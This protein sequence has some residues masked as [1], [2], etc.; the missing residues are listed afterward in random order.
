[1]PYPA[2]YGGVID[3]YYKIIA[4]HNL[5]IRIHLHCFTNN[6]PAQK[7]LLQYCQTVTYYKRK[8]ISGYRT[9]LP[10][11]VSSR[12]N[13]KL[14]TNLQKDTHPILFEGIHC[15]YLL[16]TNV[17]GSRKMCIRL[18][19]VEHLYYKKLAALEKNFFLKLHYLLEA[20]QLYKY[21]KKIAKSVQIFAPSTKD[22][23]DYEALFDADNISFL[24]VFLPYQQVISNMGIGKYC[25]YH[26]N[27][28]IN[29][30]ETAALWLIEKVFTQLKIPLV[31]AGNKPT[32]K[33]INTIKKYPNVSLVTSPIDSTMQLLIAN[34]HVNVLPSFNETGVK[35]KLLNALYNGRYCLVNN[36]GVAGSQLNKLCVLAES[37]QEYRAAITAIMEQP[38]TIQQIQ[39]R[40][41]ELKKI[42]NNKQS[43]L[44]IQTALL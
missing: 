32:I 15:T 19:N 1:M 38:F 8:T 13:N 22:C 10:F 42:Y 23:A 37:E 18:F 30:N 17:L 9:N 35:L 24:P 7:K 44:V 16:H 27:L 29:E 39:N 31:I 41:V 40:Q 43:A 20:K 36:A 26:G 33:L 14:L 34:A 6:R 12:V 4:L 3:M 21:E 28:A 25:L 11:I 2:N 5:G